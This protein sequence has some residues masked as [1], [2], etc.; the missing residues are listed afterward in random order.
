LLEGELLIEYVLGLSR[1]FAIAISHDKAVPYALRSRKE[2]ESAIALHLHAIQG[3]HDGR[4]EA[5]AIYKLLLQ[6]VGL[7]EGSKRLIIVPDGKL[8][9]E[10]LGAAVDPQ[11]RYL[12]ETH[13]ISYAPSATAFYLLSSEQSSRPKHAKLLGVGG[14]SYPSPPSGDMQSQ[15]PG[16]QLCSVHLPK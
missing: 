8:N 2:I 5:S 15:F 7:L 9:M 4:R 12:I 11:G 1:S 14:A 13:V 3:R 16:F 10:P 6:P